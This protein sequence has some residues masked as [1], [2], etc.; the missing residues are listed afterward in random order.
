M[1]TNIEAGVATAYCVFKGVPTQSPAAARDTTLDITFNCLTYAYDSD[2]VAYQQ[3]VAIAYATISGEKPFIG[4]DVTATAYASASA[5][6]IL[7]NVFEGTATAYASFSAYLLLEGLKRNWVRWSNIGDLDFTIWKDNVAGERP[8]DWKGWVYCVKKLGNRVVA[9]GENGVSLLPPA[10]VH[11]GLKT[12]YR[13]GLKSKNAITGD[14]DIYFFIDNKD[15]L[16]SMGENLELLG[17]SEYLSDMTDPVMSYDVENSLVYICD[18]TYGFVYSPKDKSLGSGPVNVTGISSQG[19]TLYVASPATI[20]TPNFAIWTDIRDMGT[21]KTKT[22]FEL[23]FGTDLEGP[24][25][26]AI[27]YRTNKAGSF[28]RTPWYEVSEGGSVFITAIGKEFKF[29]ARA[30]AWEELE[31]DYLTARGII[32]AH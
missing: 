12:I 30:L 25:Q 15:Q 3:G 4:I 7:G 21:R 26:A 23:E 32:H 10:G 5:T 17:Y 1:T 18:G 24:L 19:G 29:G 13:I 31:I 11:Y 20:V 9:Y 22:V 2:G 28:T 8:L 14:D 6:L 27:D 16:F